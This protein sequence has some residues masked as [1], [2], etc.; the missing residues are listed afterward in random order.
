MKDS[1]IY[2]TDNLSGE[3][4]ETFEKIEM[5]VNSQNVD[6]SAAEERLGELL[7][8]FC[9]AQKTGKPVLRITGN[10][11]E[12]FCR[13]FCSDFGI[14]SHVLRL[15]D[16]LKSI[17]WFLLILAFLDMAFP[18]PKIDGQGLSGVFSIP[19]SL[20]LFGY[21]IGL[22]IAGMVG[23][24]ANALLRRMMFQRRWI[25]IK[26]LRAGACTVAIAVFFI[27]WWLLDE[28][29]M[30]LIS[31]PAWIVGA[32]SIAYL[33]AYY[34]LCRERIKRPKVKF[35][36][37]VQEEMRKDMD[38]DMQKKYQRARNK[39]RKQGK[40]ELSYEAFLEQEW[41]SCNS[42]KERK[43]YYY[44]LPLVIIGAA[45]LIT[46]LLGGFDGI[47]DIMIFVGIQL[48]IQYLLMSWLWKFA[49][50]EA[51]ERKA[52]IEKR[53]GGQEPGE[54]MQK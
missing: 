13:T 3:Y 24:A 37:L 53:K 35:R 18:D 46:F 21:L 40:G 12:Q 25:S 23:M 31:C 54:S 7:D 4:R 39:S 44:L 27:I 6:E 36:D 2:Y 45:V 20:N 43:A 10:S 30:N 11:L 5:Y 29:R 14:K 8:I 50:K 28:N 9:S 15:V 17:A 52:W 19:I 1:Y 32:A 49:Y 26:A 16:W 33:L 34:P 38:G 41:K 22:G 42:V 47:S 48:V 51:L